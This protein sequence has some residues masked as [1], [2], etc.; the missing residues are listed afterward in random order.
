MEDYQKYI[1]S[2]MFPGIYFACISPT[3]EILSLPSFPHLL[4][5]DNNSP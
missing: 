3:R 5:H 2:F 1:I 4:D